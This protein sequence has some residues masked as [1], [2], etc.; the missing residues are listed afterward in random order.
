MKNPLLSVGG[1]E[2]VEMYQSGDASAL[3]E[4]ERRYSKNARKST[5]SFI[6]RCTGTAPEASDAPAPT[7]PCLN[8]MSMDAKLALITQLLMGETPTLPTAKKAPAKKAPAK[9]A[10]RT[11][12]KPTAPTG[13]Q[14]ITEA[15]DTGYACYS[16]GRGDRDGSI[17][18]LEG[19]YAYIQ[20]IYSEG[21]TAKEAR[22]G[23]YAEL[24]HFLPRAYRVTND[25]RSAVKTKAPAKVAPE[26][27]SRDALKLALGLPSSSRIP[28]AKLL[29]MVSEQSA[30]QAPATP[31]PA[32]EAENL[33]AKITALLA[34]FG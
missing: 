12:A 27:M 25:T 19:E 6:K 11:D 3:A 2:L 18:E 15:T 29:E 7:K 16:T 9:K 28:T 17:T 22:E 1:N 32:P 33:E 4:L 13:I 24:K 10:P 8:E 30:P 34:N 14:V 31:A 26:S 21:T 20:D 23:F 5:A